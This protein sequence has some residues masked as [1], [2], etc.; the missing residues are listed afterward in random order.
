[1]KDYRDQA[2]GLADLLN[3]GLMVD[4]GVMLLKD[5]AFCSGWTYSGPDMHSAS[6][7]ELLSLRLCINQAFCQL[8]DG[9]MLHSNIIRKEIT[10]YLDEEHN[11][12]PDATSL[13]IDKLRQQHFLKENT[14]FL[15]EYYFVLT[16]KPPI[17]IETQFKRFFVDDSDENTS[18]W[19]DILISFKAKLIQIENSLSKSIKLKRL[20]TNELLTHI[21]TCITGLFHSISH[22]NFPVFLDQLL[23]S[24]DF[25]GGLS[26]KIGQK[27]LAVLGINGFP[28]ESYPSMLQPLCELPISF[29]WSNRYIFLDQATSAQELKKFRRYWFQKKQG[30]LGMV[31]E[32][33]HANSTTFLDQDA[34]EMA[35]DADSALQETESNLVPYGYYTSNFIL[36][37]EDDA[38]VKEAAK[39]L[40]KELEKKGFATR[41]ET[42]N[43]VEAY[44]G[45]LPGHGYQNIRKPMVSTLNLADFL[46][47]L[48]VWN[49]HE[50][51]P[52]P[53]YPKQSP[54]LFYAHTEGKTPFRCS[55]HVDDVGHTLVIGD[56]GSGKSTLL[57]FLI[58]QHLRYPN[59]QV[60]M[61]DKGYSSFTL[62]HALGGSHYDIAGESKDISFAPLQDISLERELDWACEW[63]DI[64]YHAQHISLSPS[65]RKE[66]RLSLQRLTHQTSKTL[67]D[68][69]ATIQDQDLK[70]ALEFYTLSGTMGQLLDSEKDDINSSHVQ[71]FEMQHLLNKEE[72]FA[73]PVLDYLFH[74][75]NRRLEVTKPTL[76]L[77]EEGH[78]FLKGHFGQQLEIWLRECRK[79]NAAVIFITQGLS[80]IVNSNYKHILLNSCPTK[81]FLPNA[82]ANTVYNKELYY[83]I[84]LTDKQIDMI[85]AS[86]PKQD[87]LL[88]SPNGN[89]L[90]NLA[91]SKCF[92]ALME[93]TSLESRKFIYELKDKYQ[94]LWAY[95]YLLS[96]GMNVEAEDWMS[97]YKRK[98]E[99]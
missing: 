94:S 4:E 37:D 63:L 74:Q 56:T 46:P 25:L 14:H 88:T 23:A 83:Q 84:G 38:A 33:F 62:C 50:Y 24:K 75:I 5:G 7:S 12:F 72:K 69:Q 6:P 32:I 97:L 92:L 45:S 15:S 55:L 29:R 67:T 93:S 77:I 95:H 73:L 21:H 27:Q 64:I 68:L 76:I 66:I 47:L 28:F 61:F 30:L 10:E 86:T 2:K 18:S 8:G 26:P 42:V 43:A 70:A 16:Y 89:R 57:G 91:L 99:V 53:Y 80:E 65:Q 20:G 79:L 3:Y 59:A 85:Q 51:H 58:A 34:L 98:N 1:M 39:L 9:W 41:L 52:C 36:T 54:P 22:P 44:L 48:S 60:F 40:T 78:R 82:Y 19:K 17:E 11:F 71:V 87:Y 13:L 31:K 35:N 49:G 90:M 81:I 96:K